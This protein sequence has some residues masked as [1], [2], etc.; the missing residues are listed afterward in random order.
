MEKFITSIPVYNLLTNLIPGTIL[1]ALLKFWVE[2]C[3]VFSLTD[4]IWILAV[5][6]YFI[7]VVNSRISSLLIVP[8]L[9]K[10]KIVSGVDHVEFTKAELKDTSGKLTQLSRMGSEYRSY[11]SVFLCVIIMKLIFSWTA[12]RT[13]ITDYSCEIILIL[14]LMLFLLSYRKQVKYIISRVNSLNN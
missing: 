10:L 13:I 5:I 6:L 12:T 9:K 1:A 8:F 7:G 14:G 3:D 4:N 2:D 11:I